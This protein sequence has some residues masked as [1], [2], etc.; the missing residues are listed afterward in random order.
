VLH[1]LLYNT[2]K[3][4]LASLMLAVYIYIY[5]YIGL[6]LQKSC[7]VFAGGLDGLEERATSETLL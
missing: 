5:I 1:F 3:H 7:F 4:G 2:S 6:I